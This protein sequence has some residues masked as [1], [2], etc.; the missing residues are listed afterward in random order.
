MLNNVGDRTP[1]YG[2]LVLICLSFE[3]VLLSACLSSFY[4]VF[5]KLDG[6]VRNVC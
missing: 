2:T 1:P 3:S 5:Y 4:V 6:N